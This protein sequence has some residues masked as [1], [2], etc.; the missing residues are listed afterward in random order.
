[1]KKIAIW[2]LMPFLVF[3]PLTSCRA[4]FTDEQRAAILEEINAQERDGLISSAKAQALREVLVE[5]D[6]G[7]DWET[8]STIAGGVGLSIVG[9]LTGVRLQRGPAKPLPKSQAAELRSLLQSRKDRE[10]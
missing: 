10:A 3:P 2:A 7:V 4:F 6:G 9:A 8:I 1:M 5:S